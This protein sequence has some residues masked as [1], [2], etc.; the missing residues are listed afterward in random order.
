VGRVGSGV[1]ERRALSAHGFCTVGRA[2]LRFPC[3]HVA[4]AAI[5][6]WVVDSSCATCPSAMSALSPSPCT[7]VGGCNLSEVCCWVRGAPQ[8]LPRVRGRVRGSGLPRRAALALPSRAAESVGFRVPAARRHRPPRCPVCPRQFWL[9]WRGVPGSVVWAADD[10]RFPQMAFA[11]SSLPRSDPLSHAV[12]LWLSIVGWSIPLALL[13]GA[14]VC[15][16]LL[17]LLS[18]LNRTQSFVALVSVALRAL[19]STRLTYPVFPT[20]G[21]RAIL[22]TRWTHPRNE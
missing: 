1:G 14:D 21:I 20:F 10:G 4:L 15:C 9:A 6:S 13:R 16:D 17:E 2:A 18:S 8:G 22:L 11:S 5:K 19:V 3:S 12:R 7:G